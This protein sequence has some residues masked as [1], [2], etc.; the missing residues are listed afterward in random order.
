MTPDDWKRVKSIASEAWAQPSAERL[1]YITSACTD[2][3]DLKREVSALIAAMSAAD[4]RF[5]VPPPLPVDDIAALGSLA[6]RR[7]GAYEILSPIG[8]GGM[9]EVYKARD[10][11]LNRIV[12]IKALPPRA[13]ADPVSRERMERE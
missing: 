6:G 4:D 7:V 12:A 9:G 10:T 2:D 11:R 5:E 13:S 1:S 3:E 8:A